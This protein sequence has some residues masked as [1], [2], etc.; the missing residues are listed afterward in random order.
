MYITPQTMAQPV[1]QEPCRHSAFQDL[2]LALS[3]SVLGPEDAE[4]EEPGDEEGVAEEVEGIPV[5][6]GSDGGFDGLKEERRMDGRRKGE[7]G[8]KMS[9]FRFI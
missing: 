8:R 9:W 1:R 3:R 5:D 4:L 2:P 7:R 6:V